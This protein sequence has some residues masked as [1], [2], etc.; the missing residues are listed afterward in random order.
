M[1]IE[2][3]HLLTLFLSLYVSLVTVFLLVALYVSIYFFTL[4][5]LAQTYSKKL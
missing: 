2:M 1:L 3:S 4:Y 5:L